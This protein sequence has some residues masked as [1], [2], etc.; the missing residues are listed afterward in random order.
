MLRFVKWRIVHASERAYVRYL[1]RDPVLG[2]PYQVEYV[3]PQWIKHKAYAPRH[4]KKPAEVT[5]VVLGGNWDKDILP[6]PEFSIVNAVRARFVHDKGWEE[7]E[8]YTELMQKMENGDAPYGLKNTE[9]L[10]QH[11][12]DIEMLFDSIKMNGFRNQSEL[13]AEGNSKFPRNE[14]EVVVHIDRDGHYMFAGGRRRLSIALALGLD[15]I[16]VKV[17]IRH[18]QWESFR[19]EVVLEAKKKGGRVT[20][21]IVHPDLAFVDSKHDDGRLRMML[22][23]LGERTTGTLLDIGCEWGY[24]CHCFEEAGFDCTAVERNVRPQYFLKKLK[25]ALHRRFDV[26]GESIFDLRGTLRYDIVLA[27]NIFHHFL[28]TEELYHQLID[29]LNRLDVSV[30]YFGPH[31]PDESQMSGSYQN[32]DH[33]EFVQFV[34]DHSVLNKQKL[35]GH[36]RDGRPLYKIWRED[37]AQSDVAAPVR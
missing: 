23:D 17:N 12:R 16:P 11:L 10:D 28:K 20:Q 26:V 27:L 25:E 19:Q 9:D 37:D 21:P 18:R 6:V 14:R 7:T 4:V 29:L 32:L 30:M 1:K 31:N 36:S 33:S 3:S 22:D 15:R 5:G 8:Y 2:D 35:L 34:V 13:P 24:F